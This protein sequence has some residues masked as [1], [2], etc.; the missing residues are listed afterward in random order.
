M[1]D[2]IGDMGYFRPHNINHP[3][4]EVAQARINPQNPHLFPLVLG[5]PALARTKNIRQA[6]SQINGFSVQ[7]QKAAD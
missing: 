4:A 6:L 3:P 7:V 1:A 2:A 5:G